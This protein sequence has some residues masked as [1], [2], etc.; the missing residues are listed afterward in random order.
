MTRGRSDVVPETT[1]KGQTGIEATAITIPAGP[2]ETATIE[3]AIARS[4][5]HS[6]DMFICLAD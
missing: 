6:A 1:G 3:N 2:T 5:M 4:R